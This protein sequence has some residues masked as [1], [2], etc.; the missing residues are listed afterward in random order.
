LTSFLADSSAER[1]V[2]AELVLELELVLAAPEASLVFLAVLVVPVVLALAVL[3][4]SAPYSVASVVV[5]LPLVPVL[6][7]RRLPLLLYVIPPDFRW[8]QTNYH[9]RAKVKLRATLVPLVLEQ[10]R[11]TPVLQALVRLRATLVP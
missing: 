10:P 1:G 9:D 7:V 6:L 2:L 8:P 5:T 11:A 3:V 4:V